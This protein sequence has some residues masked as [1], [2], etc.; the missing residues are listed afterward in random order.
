MIWEEVE[1]LGM[2][3][4]NPSD[5]WAVDMDRPSGKDRKGQERSCVD[6]YNPPSPRLVAFATSV[7]G[8]WKIC[9]FSW[10]NSNLTRPKESWAASDCVNGVSVQLWI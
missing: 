4:D 2:V 5:A 8:A 7:Y 10:N 9:I 1:L 6:L 3:D